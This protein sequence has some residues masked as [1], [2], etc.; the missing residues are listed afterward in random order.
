M[1]IS[2]TPCAPEK[3]SRETGSDVPSR[4][5]LL[6][7]ILRLNIL[8]LTRGVPPDF[9]SGVHFFRP[10][11]AVALVPSLSGHAIVHLWRSLP[12]VHRYRSIVLKVV[13]VTGTA[14]ADHHG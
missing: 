14:F 4:A 7:S 6:I 9:G 13:P 8:M 12:R 11:Y 3:W 1:N 2:L 5:S 10:P